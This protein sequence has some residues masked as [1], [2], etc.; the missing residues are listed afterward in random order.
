MCD[1]PIVSVGFLII[2]RKLDNNVSE[3]VNFKI[4]TKFSFSIWH[5]SMNVH[6]EPCR[7]IHNYHIDKNLLSSISA[8]AIC[9]YSSRC[10]AMCTTQAVLIEKCRWVRDG[11]TRGLMFLEGYWFT[12]ALDPTPQSFRSCH[13]HSYTPSN[14]LDF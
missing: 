9:S 1:Q 10:V 2:F 5:N 13:V 8:S 14:V 6:T 7:Y 11:A 3:V 4:M 12:Y